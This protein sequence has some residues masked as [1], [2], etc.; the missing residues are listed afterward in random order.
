MDL[1]QSPNNSI[2]TGDSMEVRQE[3]KLRTNIVRIT[4][5]EVPHSF[6]RLINGGSGTNFG[7]RSFLAFASS[8]NR[9]SQSCI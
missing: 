4:F 9:A 8:S 2:C 7:S 6:A 1:L 5:D 3:F